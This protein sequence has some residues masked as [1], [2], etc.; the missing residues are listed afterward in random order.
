MSRRILVPLLLAALMVPFAVA[1]D[2]SGNQGD[3]GG[4]RGDRG[5]R[6]RGGPGGGFDPAA[7]RQ[8]MMD[9]IKERMGVTND[10]EW[11][12]IQ[13]K[14][15][16]V[17]QKSMEVRAGGMMGGFRGR[18]GDDNDNGRARSAV[19]T[20]SRELRTTLDNKSASED[21][22][23]AKLTAFRE[24]REKARTELAA[25]QKDLKEIL[26]PRQEAVLVQFGV[27]D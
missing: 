22:I 14:L 7:M 17:M 9:G 13:A 4:D 11:K 18:G 16:P 27:I 1:Q 26:M 8:R 19:E 24:A 10:D 5:E 20:A 2:N 3:R 25:A 21:D 6:G 15:E 23:K 12:V